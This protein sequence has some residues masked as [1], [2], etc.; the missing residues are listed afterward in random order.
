MRTDD[1]D[2]FAVRSESNGSYVCARHP[3]GDEH[4]FCWDGKQLVEDDMTPAAGFLPHLDPECSLSEAVKHSRAAKVAAEKFVRRTYRTG[5]T[6]DMRAEWLRGLREWAAA[7]DNVRQL[8]L[9]GSR[10]RGDA[11]ENSDVDIALALMPRDGKHDWAFGNYFALEGEWKG[12]LKAIVERDV[13]L[14]PL[15]PESR[16]DALVRREGVLLWARLNVLT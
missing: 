6:M 10:A 13:D 11:R 5:R 12:Q 7:N 9:F 14:E 2:Q 1:G 15:V 3:D 8:W 16:V 4:L